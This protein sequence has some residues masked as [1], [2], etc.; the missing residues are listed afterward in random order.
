MQAASLP[1]GHR[2]IPSPNSGPDSQDRLLIAPKQ[3][4]IDDGAVVVDLLPGPIDEAEDAARP[5]GQVDPPLAVIEITFFPSDGDKDVARDRDFEIPKLDPHPG[6]PEYVLIDLANFRPAPL[7][8]SEGVAH[9]NI[10]PVSMLIKTPSAGA[11]LNDYAHRLSA[12]AEEAERAARSGE[13][14]GGVLRLGALETTAA[15]RPPPPL[16]AFR[17]AHPQVRLRLSTRTSDE[18]LRMV[19]DFRLDAALV[20][21]PAMSHPELLGEELFVEELVLAMSDMPDKSETRPSLLVF[22]SGCAYRE[23]LEAWARAEGRVP[24]EIMEIGS[25]EGILGGL[26]AGLGIT[27]LPR[28]VFGEAAGLRILPLPRE[29]SRLPIMLVRRADA[30]PLAS[31]E[32]FGSLVRAAMS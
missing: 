31:L 25:L 15:L 11:V 10:G 27:A 14:P 2:P 8:P 26:R 20:G 16:I 12:L 3:E 32:S 18:L 9:G 23:R 4:G 24:Y 29:S 13:G 19:L 21:L 28:I 6:P 7:R 30:P 1:L 22:R 5:N 17:H